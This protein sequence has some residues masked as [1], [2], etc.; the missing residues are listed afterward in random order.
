MNEPM[1]RDGDPGIELTDQ[2]RARPRAPKLGDLPDKLP[3]RRRDTVVVETISVKLEVVT[4]IL[5]GA[6]RPRQIDKVDIIRVPTI[7]GHLRFWWR[8]LYGHDFV[9]DPRGLFRA[10]STLFGRAARDDVEE[11]RSRVDIRV[12][13]EDIAGLD[14]ADIQLYD[15]KDK[16]GRVITPET[17]GSYALW[18]AQSQKED[19]WTN[20]PYVPPAPR[21]QPGSVFTLKLTAPA[22]DVPVLR[23]VLRAW[24]LFGGY[25]GRTRRG[26]GSLTYT[27]DKPEEWLPSGAT[28]AEIN[29][30]FEE[31]DDIFAPRPAGNTALLSG[32]TLLV[33]IPGQNAVNAWTTSLGW[34]KEFRQGTRSRARETGRGN[35]P[36]ISN[37]PEADVLRSI[38]TAPSH[39][40]SLSK[41]VHKPRTEY[42]S[43]RAWPRADFGLPINGRFQKKSEW[44][45]QGLYEPDDFALI[46]HD[47]TRPHD[48]LA[49]PL[50]LKPM[51]LLGGHFAAVALWLNRRQPDGHVMVSGKPESAARFDEPFVT[52]QGV[53]GFIADAARGPLRDA[54]CNW[55]DSSKHLRRLA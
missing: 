43:G 7:R 20:K 33:E 15:R 21:R 23:N 14:Q 44:R 41:L 31:I 16:Q 5:G 12:Q 10:E 48:R 11:G 38:S 39:K 6:A 28:R 35:H 19:R 27:G 42:T 22:D 9:G 54:F 51:P 49:S 55:L 25:G 30:R 17:K 46:W 2:P 26:L 13:M 40:G 29:A 3:R 4:P 52:P 37:W 50:V 32:A 18:T 8:A 47:G 1:Q 34:L 36:S 24:I 45:D 53:P